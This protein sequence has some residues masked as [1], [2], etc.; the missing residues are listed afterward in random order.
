MCA[1]VGAL[2]DQL[3]TRKGNFND[4]LTYKK[5][6][7]FKI[8]CSLKEKA[9]MPCKI[10]FSFPDWPKSHKISLNSFSRKLI[11]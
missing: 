8:C 7:V 4:L 2:L 6:H 11:F 9:I 3:K 5:K 10:D 1:L